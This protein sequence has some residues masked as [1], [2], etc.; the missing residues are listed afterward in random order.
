MPKVL[1][2]AG[3]EYRMNVRRPGFILFTLAVPV[4]GLLLLAASTLFG[5]RLG[6]FLAEQFAVQPK[7]VTE[8]GVVDESDMLLPIRPKYEPQYRAFETE[9]AGREALRDETIGALL[10]VPEDYLAQGEARVLTAEEIPILELPGIETFFVDHLLREAVEPQLRERLADPVTLAHTALGAP[11]E[12]EREPAEMVADFLL[13]F[14]LAMLLAISIFT[15]T[16]YLLEGVAREK[17]TRIV[18][19]L[20]SSVSSRELLVGKVMGLAA[21][22]LTQIG[23]WI[24]SALLL[25][26]LGAQLLAFPLAWQVLLGRAD[27]LALGV[28]YYLLGYLLYA[29]IVAGVG[30]LGTSL[31]ESQQLAGF[32]TFLAIIPLFFAGAIINNPHSAL[33]QVLSFFPLTTPTAMLVRLPAGASPA[34]TPV[35]LGEILLS[36]AILVASILAVLWLGAKLFRLGLLIYGQRPSLGRIW[37]AL[38]EA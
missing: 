35:P 30:A 4:L 34:A 9:E 6:E 11:A 19:I 26:W 23:V 33:A 15:S 28:L 12:P 1:T 29:V 18:E 32:S 21:L 27:F 25:G 10:V 17:E 20:V 13:P 31:Q 8:V 3:H 5:A 2:I 14:A 22:G 36:L 37:R 24:S 7:V 38:R 16:G